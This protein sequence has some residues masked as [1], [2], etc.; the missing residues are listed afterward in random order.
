MKYKNTRRG[1]KSRVYEEKN[2]HTRT[3]FILRTEM[4]KESVSPM[5]ERK[6]LETKE[7][8]SDEPRM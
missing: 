6:R 4:F 7:E 8:V 2:V 3:R 1:M 5:N